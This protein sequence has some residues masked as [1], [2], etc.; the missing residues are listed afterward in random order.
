MKTRNVAN[1]IIAYVLAVVA[2]T[3]TMA[4]GAADEP[5]PNKPVRF[6]VPFAAG[7]VPDVLGR[8]VA[9]KLTQIHGKPFIL[10]NRAG[11]A[12]NIGTELA[13][14]SNPD[15]YTFLIGSSGTH[16]INPTLYREISYDPIRDFS[17]ISLLAVVPN[18]LVVTNKFPASSVTEFI[19]YARTNPGKINYG[20]IGN[21]SS[22]HLAATQFESATGVKMTHIPYKSV[23]QVVTDLISGQI[24]TMFQL[25]P[26]IVR[27]VKAGQVRALGVTTKKRSLA[28]P[29]VP[30]IAES[31]VPNYDTAG[32]FGLFAPKGT[33]QA[34]IDTLSKNVRSILSA[35][36]VKQKLIELGAEPEPSDPAEFA[37]FVAAELHR[38]RAIVQS[39]GA[40]VD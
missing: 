28:L 6:V 19:V 37:T 15:G 18:V 32:W 17:P 24:D 10:D 11:A 36:E 25:V 22:Q 1:R 12:G 14:K 9:D 2:M 34:V 20:S 23:P 21:G 3:L 31:G 40:T 4:V 27:Q 26:N 7:G 30:T 13:A 39:S 33:P 5:W 29:G 35:P 8:I 38:W 16:A